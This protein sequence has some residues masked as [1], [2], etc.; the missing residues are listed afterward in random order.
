M[1]IRPFRI[2]LWVG[3]FALAV[4]LTLLLVSLLR[5]SPEDPGGNI[6]WLLSYLL[7]LGFPTSLVVA[8]LGYTG[9]S[10]WVVLTAMIAAVAL[11]WGL[12]G[13]LLA[14]IARLLRGRP[15]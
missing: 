7:L 8:L 11:N 15:S 6:E 4:A 1:T 14:S 2:A 5:T 13:F 12:A 10:A 9:A 3:A